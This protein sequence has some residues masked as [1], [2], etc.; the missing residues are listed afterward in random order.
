[1]R[2]CGASGPLFAPASWTIA[3]SCELSNTAV[4]LKERHVYCEP[5][6]AD[7]VPIM[8]VLP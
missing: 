5:D 1:M 2:V 6:E 7:L 4:L 8:R 3:G